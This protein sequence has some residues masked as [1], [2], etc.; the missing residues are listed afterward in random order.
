MARPL[1]FFNLQH[2][3]PLTA[4]NLLSSLPGNRFDKIFFFLSPIY[5]IIKFRS[6]NLKR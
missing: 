5:D 6:F 3:L 1:V 4:G 2:D